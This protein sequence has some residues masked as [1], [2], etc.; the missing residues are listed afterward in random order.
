MEFNPPWRLVRIRP[1][2]YLRSTLTTIC[3][4]GPNVSF[5]VGDGM[6]PGLGCS[7]QACKPG[8]ACLPSPSL[9]R[10]HT[11]KCFITLDSECISEFQKSCNKGTVASSIPVVL[12][13]SRHV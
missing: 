11:H 6:P 1:C 13:I 12:N 7:T 5:R 3:R 9:L 8:A 10:A 2:P 4:L